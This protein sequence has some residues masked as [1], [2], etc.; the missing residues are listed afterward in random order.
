MLVGT[1][2][3]YWGAPDIEDDVPEDCFVDMRKF[4]AGKNYEEL[5]KFLYALTP[6]ELQRRKEAIR[7][8]FES[9]QFKKF[10][11][12]YFVETILKIVSG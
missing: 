5:R 8:Y 3:V 2:P 6:E 10:T 9:A 4:S 1:I 11:P 7:A 12:E